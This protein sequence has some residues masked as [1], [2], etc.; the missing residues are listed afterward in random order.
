LTA[1]NG[2]WIFVTGSDNITLNLSGV[3]PT[4]ISIILKSGWNLIGT[5]I[6]TL[7]LPSNVNITSIF[8]YT[9]N[10]FSSIATTSALTANNGYWIFVTGTD[11]IT[12]NLR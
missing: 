9:N 5:S 3:I 11:D 4:T 1:N 8:Q 7:S 12:I 2:Y 10:N 6:D